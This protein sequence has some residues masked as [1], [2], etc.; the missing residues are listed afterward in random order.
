METN[1]NSINP[2][3]DPETEDLNKKIEKMEELSA[4]LKAENDR[5]E[6]LNKQREILMSKRILAGT[7]E[8]GAPIAPPV[9]PEKAAID[10]RVK[11][12]GMS[13]NSKWARAMP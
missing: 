3:V 7:S 13:T 2:P 4:K 8:A 1:Q 11:A 5:T 6:I 9:D 10:A 12:L